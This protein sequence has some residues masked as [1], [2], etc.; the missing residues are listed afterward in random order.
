[1]SFTEKEI[2]LALGYAENL[3]V[4]AKLD[5]QDG[6]SILF[7]RSDQVPREL[8]EDIKE[9]IELCIEYHQRSVFTGEYIDGDDNPP[10]RYSKD[11]IEDI[12]FNLDHYK[13]KFIEQV[14]KA[15]D[16]DQENN[17]PKERK[18]TPYAQA[19][20]DFQKKGKK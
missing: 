4:I 12:N 17:Q 20:L 6:K 16:L 18:L 14:R 2:N 8:S 13:P 11:P 10:A 19:M 5:P 15:L 7:Y 3:K 9:M 1:M